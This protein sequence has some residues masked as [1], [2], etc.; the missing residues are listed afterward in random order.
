[1]SKSC[2]FDSFLTPTK[3]KK[4]LVSWKREHHIIQLNNFQY[5]TSTR[6]SFSR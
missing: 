4:F 1:M 5:I 2:V 3:N 6:S